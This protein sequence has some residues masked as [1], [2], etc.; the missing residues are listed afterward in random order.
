MTK[1]TSQS[2]ITAGHAAAG[3]ALGLLALVG[4][5][6]FNASPAGRPAAEPPRQVEPSPSPN[7]QPELSPEAPD[8]TPTSS[9]SP[10][11]SGS[12]TPANT[13]CRNSYEPSCGPFFWDPEPAP[14]R[15]LIV[16]IVRYSPQHPTVGDTIT[17]FIR[18]RDAD[19]AFGG[20]WSGRFGEQRFLTPRP[21]R[22]CHGG[23]ATGPWTPP[24]ARAGDMIVQHD[25]RADAPGIFE[26]SFS[27]ESQSGF[28]PPGL[29]CWPLDP[30]ESHGTSQ[31]VTVFVAPAGP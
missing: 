6:R 16:E 30:Y 8:P 20:L 7:H 21:L 14:N 11:A 1:R 29:R 25:F 26:T 12:A 31:T 3:A 2:H 27:A 13:V 4:S 24:A 19:A 28:H 23:P 10:S 5:A 17:F 22:P 9:A 18:L 15:P